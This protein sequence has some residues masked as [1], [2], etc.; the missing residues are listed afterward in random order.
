MQKQKLINL[1]TKYDI[2]P[3]TSNSP[4]STK[5]SV[6]NNILSVHHLTQQVSCRLVVTIPGVELPDTEFGV[7]DPQRLQK[8]LQALDSEINIHITKDNVLHLSDSS[9]DAQFILS[10][11]DVIFNDLNKDPE[12]ERPFKDIPQPNVEFELTKEF[13]TKFVKACS[14]LPEAAIVAISASTMGEQSGVD[15]IINYSSHQTNQIRLSVPGTVNSDLELVAFNAPFLQEILSK[16]SDF[17]SGR[18]TIFSKMIEDSTRGPRLAAGLDLDFN[19]SD[20]AS[21]YR[22]QKVEI[23]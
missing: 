1:L 15:F 16:N 5:W 4:N 17:E 9:S 21:K 23:I 10:P 6:R 2:G 3:T 14:A 13:C 12:I 19:S 18:I 7:Y 11:L 22:L 8:M 20:F